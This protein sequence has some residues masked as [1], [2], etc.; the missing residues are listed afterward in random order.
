M[1]VAN[2]GATTMPTSLKN[3]TKKYLN[4]RNLSLGTRR[5]YQTTI[6][7]WQKWKGRVSIERLDRPTIREFLSWVHNRAIADGAQ[8]LVELPIKPAR[9][10]ERSFLG[11]G[12]TISSKCHLGFQNPYHLRT[13]LENTI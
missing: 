1:Q 13:L 2:A 4:A 5:E 7:K 8:I 10:F 6:T 11:L 3:A 9:T 12:R